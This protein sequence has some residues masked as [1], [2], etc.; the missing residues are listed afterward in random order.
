MYRWWVFTGGGS[1]APVPGEGSRPPK[2]EGL[3]WQEPHSATTFRPARPSPPRGHWGPSG[4]PAPGGRPHRWPSGAGW[5]LSWGSG[6]GRAQAGLLTLY[7]TAGGKQLPSRRE[8]KRPH[9]RNRVYDS[10]CR[11]THTCHWTH[12]HSEDPLSAPLMAEM[13]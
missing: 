3:A 10:S 12:T 6:G 2:E 8:A 13:T 7:C 1:S 5:R 4:T 9:A 11:I